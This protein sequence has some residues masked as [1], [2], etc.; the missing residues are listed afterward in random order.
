MTITQVN[1]APTFSYGVGDGAV[2][3]GVSAGTDGIKSTAVQDDGKIL[4]AGYADMDVTAGTD[5]DF[6]ASGINAATTPRNT[7]INN[8][9]VIGI[10]IISAVTR[11]GRLSAAARRNGTSRAASRLTWSYW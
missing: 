2:I 9:S 7:R 1:E 11:S 5:Y 6:P 3:T 8:N 4:L 10:A